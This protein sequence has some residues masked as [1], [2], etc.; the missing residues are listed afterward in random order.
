[1]KKAN[2]GQK[3]RSVTGK[4]VTGPDVRCMS[5]Q[6]RRPVL[7]PWSW[8]ADGSH[9]LLNGSLADVNAEFQEFPTDTLG[10]EDADSAPPFRLLKATVSGA[11]FGV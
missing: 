6:E 8:C 7:S 1:M 10:S 2:R 5:V 3:K 9:V 11:T 4:R